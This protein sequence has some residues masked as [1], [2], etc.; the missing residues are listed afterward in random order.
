M[1]V[2]IWREIVGIDGG[3][4]ADLNLG[5]AYLGWAPYRLLI[6]LLVPL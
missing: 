4:N 1:A 6:K 2:K 5:E 3:G